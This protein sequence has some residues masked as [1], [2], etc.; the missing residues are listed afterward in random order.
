MNFSY[1]PSDL[2]LADAPPYQFNYNNRNMTMHWNGTDSL[3]RYNANIQNKSTK[4][5]L[6]KN[7]WVNSVIEYSYN[8][9]GF[10]CQEFDDR[11]SGLAL[12]CSFT[13]GTGLHATQTWPFLL[14][15]L[16]NQHVWNLG[17]GGAS[18]DTV[19]R[20]L[21]HYIGRLNVRFVCILLPPESRFEYRDIENGFPIIQVGNLGNHTGFAMEW[22]AQPFNATYNTRKT[23]LAAQQICENLEIPVFVM[24]SSDAVVENQMYNQIDLA[25]DLWHRG[26]LYQKYVAEFMYQQV[27]NFLKLNN[28]E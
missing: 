19:F 14:A 24:P 9:H 27:N 4:H 25:R 8:S 10:R 22:L 16:T 28:D 26:P 23:M 13:E 20:I 6:E 18:I 12:G 7:G 3:E 2:S 5:L 11:I 1:S 21:D 15:K 17:S